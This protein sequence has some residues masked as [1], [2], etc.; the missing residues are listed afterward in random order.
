MTKKH[1][2]TAVTRPQAQ[3]YLNKAKEF[4]VASREA[5]KEDR[6]NSAGLLAIHAAISSADALLGYQAGYRSTSPDHRV[7]A[8]LLKELGVGS[9]DRS[10][11]IRRFKRILSKKNIV[12]YEARQITQKE[13]SYLV[14]QADRFVNWAREVMGEE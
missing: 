11:Q 3:T 8:T 6:W 9:A 5:M 4:L 10:D 12:E 14:E 2:T 7:A 13:A 1:R